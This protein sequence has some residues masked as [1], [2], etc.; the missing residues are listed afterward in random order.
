MK[1][2]G[3]ISALL[4]A[5]SLSTP[6]MAA[7]GKAMGKTSGMKIALSDGFGGNSWHQTAWASWRAAAED[8]IANGL[9][10]EHKLISANGDPNEQ[11]SHIQ[12]LILEGYDAIVLD[13]SSE[14]ALNGTIQEACDA[15]ILVVVFDSIATAPCATP[16]TF[17]FHSY[18]DIQTRYVSELLGGK[19]NVFEIRGMAGT[20]ADAQISG[21][22]NDALAELT[23][24]NKVGEVYGNWTQSIA[25]KEVASILPTLPQVD[26]IVTQ[27]GDGY[28]AYQAF[29]AAGRDIPIIV[30]GNRQDELAL[31]K[32]LDE[33]GD[34][35][36]I[37]MSAAPQIASI[38]FWVAQQA[39][40]GKE[41][42]KSIEVPLLTI[43]ADTRDAWLEVTEEGQVASPEYPLDWVVSLIDANAKGLSGSD[44]P[45]A[46][47]PVK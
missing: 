30:M 27:G 22:T 17:N 47:V 24:L 45:T 18:G 43:T 2:I 32:D 38:A 31:W 3:L 35:K 19:G 40:A 7:D 41:L 8:A 29:K 34:Y 36:T 37:S 46:P 1:T 39:L 4:I 5:T 12:S 25:Q 23:G 28:G 10:S 6:V 16:V 21:G 42:P 20:G 11:T 9:I 13:A 26:A 14:T 44:L 33:A 15:G